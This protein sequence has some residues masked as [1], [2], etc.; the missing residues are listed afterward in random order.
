MES[1]NPYLTAQ[2][3]AS[4]DR[5]ENQGEQEPTGTNPYPMDI[6]EPEQAEPGPIEPDDDEEDN[7]DELSQF[8]RSDDGSQIQDPHDEEEQQLIPVSAVPKAR[9]VVE[10]ER[11]GFRAQ[12]DTIFRIANADDNTTATKKAPPGAKGSSGKFKPATKT[13]TKMTSPQAEPVSE[14]SENVPKHGRRRSPRPK[15]SICKSMPSSSTQP[16]TRKAPQANLP[17]PLESK[18]QSSSGDDDAAFTMWFF[19][20]VTEEEVQPPSEATVKQEV[21]PR[22]AAELGGDPEIRIWK[23][24]KLTKEQYREIYENVMGTTCWAAGAG[25]QRSWEHLPLAEKE[26]KSGAPTQPSVPGDPRGASD[27]DKEEIGDDD[28]E[29][30]SLYEASFVEEE[31]ELETQEMKD[32]P[33]DDSDHEDQQGGITLN[34]ALV[35][36]VPET[37]IVSIWI[38][39]LGISIDDFIYTSITDRV[40]MR[41]TAFT[42]TVYADEVF[43]K[44]ATT[45]QAA[46]VQERCDNVFIDESTVLLRS[47]DF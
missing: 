41:G 40:S 37:D 31:M 12:G 21:E 18:P 9:S 24:Q 36:R 22:P 34:E 14:A 43:C 13:K 11:Q 3:L 30:G 28:E 15:G 2:G 44:M 32:K 25:F 5:E 45:R 8:I 29:E 42:H 39:T 17:K 46:R 33:V 19:G 47:H 38:G 4:T 6:A 26:D 27:N 23:E 20:S 7:D 10:L 16:A 1:T 35:Q